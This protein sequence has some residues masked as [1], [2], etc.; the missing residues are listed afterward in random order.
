MVAL[1]ITDIKSFM[2]QLFHGASFDSFLFVEGDIRT[3]IDYHIDG[4]INFSFYSE[5][6]LEEL[7]LEEYQ[8]WASTKTIVTQMIK[9]RRLPVAMKFV[10]K[11][12]GKGDLTYLLSVRFD[13]SNL[14]V[15]TGVSRS[16]FSLDHSGEKEWDDNVRGF[17]T[18]N[19][20]DFEEME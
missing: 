19:G 10:L 8:D 12:A 16:G 7:K 3:A 17:L 13:N 20:V 6:E 9:G 5:E 11:K 15:V 2:A 4:K 14:I 18:K 1:H